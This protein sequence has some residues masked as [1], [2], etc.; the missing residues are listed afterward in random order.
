MSLSRFGG[1]RSA[2]AFVVGV[3]DV[4]NLHPLAASLHG[5]DA[6]ASIVVSEGRSDVYFPSSS[7]QSERID[8]H[9]GIAICVDKVCGKKG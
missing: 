5:L 8:P 7:T 1:Y 9:R 4:F 2:L 6:V 3:L